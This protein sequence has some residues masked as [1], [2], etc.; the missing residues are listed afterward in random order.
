MQRRAPSWLRQTPIAHRGLHD[1]AL[2]EN[3][4]AAF[5]AAIAAGYAIELDVHLGSG[6]ELLVFHDDDLR[7]MT[8]S[9]GS[10]ATTPWS[11]LAT[12]RLGASDEPIPRL[13]AVLE[14][15]AGRVPLVVEVKAGKRPRATAIAVAEAVASYEGPLA[16]QSF[17]PFA[18]AQLRR[19][20]PEVVLG[21]LSC[22]FT[23]MQLPAVQKFALRRLLLAPLSRPDYIGYE[24]GALPHWAP[25][26]AR[27]LG[28]P[29]VAWTV[30]DDA[31]LQ[32][33]RSLADNVIFESV[34]P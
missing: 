4:L 10:I 2:P 16:L 26:L 11:K 27:R 5:R 31:Q 19:A 28:L 13:G 17:H 3:S 23:E 15:V 22:D 9:G 1:G 29:L 20:L 7:R 25:T 12:L 21:V 34:R 33:A 30:R 24:L 32:R 14:C 6:G 8:G 18:L